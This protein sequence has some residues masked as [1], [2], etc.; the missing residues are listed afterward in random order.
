VLATDPDAD[1]GV[2]FDPDRRPD[3]LSTLEMVQLYSPVWSPS[4]PP[5]TKR[6]G[7]GRHEAK[8]KASYWTRMTEPGELRLAHFSVREYLI[9]DHLR[10]CDDRLSFYSFNKT[11]AN[12]FI[13]RTC[14][15]YLLQLS[16]PGCVSSSTTE[17]SDYAARHWMGHAQSDESDSTLHRLIMDLLQPKAAMNGN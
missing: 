6:R 1:D 12:T 17:L 2:L 8:K 5:D 15:A 14:L 3:G 13:A 4:L 7:I 16:Q 9:S 11:I 10:H